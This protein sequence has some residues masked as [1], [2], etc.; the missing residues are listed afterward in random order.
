MTKKYLVA[1]AT[2]ID[3]TLM[4]ALDKASADTGRS[5]AG[6]VEDAIREWLKKGGE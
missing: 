4:Q 2:R 5:K 1:L 3:I 6:I